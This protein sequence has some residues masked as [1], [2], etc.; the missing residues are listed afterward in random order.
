LRIRLTRGFWTSRL[1]LTLLGLVG[2]T[3]LT[4]AA[5]F[6]Y[7]YIT[8]SRMIDQ[9]M[10]GQVFQNTSRVFSAPRRISVGE[11]WGAAEMAGYLQRAGYTEVD[12]FGAPGRFSKT[13]ATVE[14]RPSA[15]SYFARKNA[16]RVEF[17]GGQ[18]SRIVSL[19]S[20]ASLP[21]AELEPELLT[22]LFDSSREKRRL[23]RFEDLPRHVIDAVLA[24][25]DKRFFEHPGFD[26]VRVVGAAWVDLRKGT[27]EQGASTITMQV[28][29]SFFFSTERTWR[30]KLSELMV[31]LQLEQ[32]FTK[33]QIFELYANQIYLGNRGSFA[34]H[35]FGEAAKAYFGKDLRELTLGEAAFLAGIIRAP[36]RYSAA[37]RNP[38]RAAEARDRVLAQMVENK[39][40]TAEQAAAAKKVA[41]R[42]VSGGVETSAAPYFVDMVKDY[43]ENRFPEHDL[44][45]ESLRVYTTLDPDLQRAAAAAVEIGML[46]LDKQLARRYER[47]R[48]RGERVPVPQVAVVVMDPRTGEI[49]AL[50]GGRDYGQSQLNRALARRQPGSVFKPFVYAAAFAN[51]VDERTPVVTPVTTI[52]D[53]PTTFYFE[54]KEY[55]PNNYGEE[56]HGTVTMRE[57]LMRSLNVATVKV[58]ELVGFDRVVEVARR[59]GLD[60]RIQPTPAVALGAYEMTPIDVAAGYTVFASRGSRAEPLFMRRV[61][62]SESR[63]LDENRPRVR[64]A[65][66][67]RV[68][69]LVTNLLQDVVNRG[70][71]AGVRTRGFTAPAAGKTGTSHDGWFAG[72][73]PNLLC[74]VWVGFDD[75][76]ELG[77][78][79]A[80]S[81]APVWAEFMKRATAMPAWASMEGFEPPEGV[82]RLAIDPETLQLATPAC[83]NTRDEVFIAGTEPVDF[84]ERH[85]GRSLSRIPPAS[86]LSRLFGGKKEPPAPEGTEKPDPAAKNPETI[87]PPGTKP[88]PPVSPEKKP[89]A[90]PESKPLASAGEEKKKGP[91]QRIFGIFGGGK[92]KENPR[93]SS[94]KP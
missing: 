80:S 8:F 42:P 12:V 90:P 55:A 35:G 18:V 29:R 73:T 88:A 54:D 33:E 57:A 11:T 75:N 56:F 1:G 22:N 14:V 20:R 63:T 74:V 77:I 32:R 44:A 10:S 68:A 19:E 72:F 23:V 5:F 17:T 45:A 26:P 62:S 7:Y 21:S 66:D 13:A 69:Y 48:K 91:L 60:P 25:E 6:T 52:V 67:P 93:P 27:K 47:W 37:E 28:A 4:G 76:R 70:T 92:K 41:L 50:V 38:E 51:A 36:N 16:L 9:R 24:A 2:V 89:D 81:A 85:G 53:E 94:S 39:Y 58:G 61:V 82:V 43:L 34:I 31:A 84:C 64:P 49:K 59:I 86:W 79:G 40:L 15:Y 78:S 83:P 87:P 65:L 46:E 30:R 3:F 71:A